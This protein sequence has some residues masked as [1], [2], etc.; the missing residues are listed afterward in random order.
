M[1]KDKIHQ[2][3]NGF[4]QFSIFFDQFLIK[5]TGIGTRRLKS[6]TFELISLQRQNWIENVDLKSIRYQYKSKFQPKSIQWPKLSF[7]T[8]NVKF[9]QKVFFRHI[10]EK[11]LSEIQTVWKPNSY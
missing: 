10:L 2:K 1:E 11:K 5:S 7:K 4:F 6:D 3:V 9:E 8:Q